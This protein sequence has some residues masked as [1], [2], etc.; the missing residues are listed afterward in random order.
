MPSG[1]MEAEEAADVLYTA[2]GGSGL[3][4]SSLVQL[5]AEVYGR[6]ILGLPAD[7]PFL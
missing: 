2:S 5:A 7:T 3:A 1:R 6:V 4:E